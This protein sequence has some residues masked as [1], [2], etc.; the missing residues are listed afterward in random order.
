MNPQFDPAVILEP[1]TDRAGLSLA[2]ASDLAYEDEGAI[3]PQLLDWSFSDQSTVFN[4]EEIQ[5]F[6]AVNDELLILC[7]RGTKNFQ[8]WLYNL[9]VLPTEDALGKVHRGFSIGLDQVWQAEV[10]PIIQEYAKG[11]T[12]WYTGHS[13]GAALATLA[14]ARTSVELPEVAIKGIATFGQPR[15]ASREF[16]EAFDAI[17]ADSF[18]R[19][20]NNRDIVPRVPPGYHHVGQLIHFDAD[21]NI[22]D[23]SLTKLEA[24]AGEEVVH[25]DMS[26]VEFEDLQAALNRAPVSGSAR[27]P[28]GAELEMMLEGKIEGLDI[29]EGIRDHSLSKGY[30]PALLKNV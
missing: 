26:E 16:E 18:Y 8:D 10:S 9:R 25:D 12:V 29:I 14:A 22:I 24:F 11:R 23:P 6:I 7:F 5:G 28:L 21:G 13:L 4:K 2:L 27:D 19:Y 30:I 17:F 1:Y 15:L 20:V 3:Q